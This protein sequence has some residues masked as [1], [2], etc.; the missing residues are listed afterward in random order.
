M[1]FLPLTRFSVK[2]AYNR[3]KNC[4]LSDKEK[5]NPICTVK[6]DMRVRSLWRQVV[7]GSI[8]C[9][10]D[11]PK[12]LSSLQHHH[13]STARTPC[14]LQV[15]MEAPGCQGFIYVSSTHQRQFGPLMKAVVFDDPKPQPIGFVYL[16]AAGGLRTPIGC[17]ANM[18]RPLRKKPATRGFRRSTN[19][20]RSRPSSISTAVMTCRSY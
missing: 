17:S 15:A 6:F 4:D 14:L 3:D 5:K 9:N 16:R 1:S 13:N 19:D 7:H 11:I 2:H 8:L 12:T 18:P 10:M 20:V